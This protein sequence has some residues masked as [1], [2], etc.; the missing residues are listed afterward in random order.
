MTALAKGLRKA[1][2]THANNV[3]INSV[4]PLNKIKSCFN[5]GP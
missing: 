5:V 2:K 4:F 3:S 1:F